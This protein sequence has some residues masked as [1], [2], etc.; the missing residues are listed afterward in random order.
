MSTLISLCLGLGLAACCGFRVFVPLL[1]ANLAS[2]A[3]L[4]HFGAGFEWMGTWAAFAIFLSAT[5]AEIAAYYIPVIDNVLDTIATPMAIGAGTLL[6]TSYLGADFSPA[7]KWGL[8]LLVGGGAAGIV[9]TGTNLLRL[10]STTT[11]G[12]LGNAAVST[13]ENGMSVTFSALAIIIPVVVAII[14]LVFIIYV[15]RS[16]VRFFKKRRERQVPG[17]VQA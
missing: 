16:L 8:G 10:G 5:I 13:A 4:Y 7:L 1:A 3:G 6:T 12:G 17:A 11:T 2:L 9:Q 14:A 15:L